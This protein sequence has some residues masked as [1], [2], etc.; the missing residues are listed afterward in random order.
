MG[1]GDARTYTSLLRGHSGHAIDHIIVSIEL[2]QRHV[3]ISL[4][5][6]SG[7]VV[8]DSSREIERSGELLGETVKG[9]DKRFLS[10]AESTNSTANDTKRSIC[11]GKVLAHRWSGILEWG[12][13]K[14]KER[15]DSGCWD[16]KIPATRSKFGVWARL[17]HACTRGPLR[18]SHYPRSIALQVS[19]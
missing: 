3:G 12:G 4:L 16:G 2:L 6:Q 13:K 19:E 1:E 8:L 17:T 5:M 14:W 15:T 11:G 10:F 9:V 18:T 7:S